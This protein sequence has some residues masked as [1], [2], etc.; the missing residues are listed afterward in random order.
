[1]MLLR[2]G[3]IR[4]SP[5]VLLEKSEIVVFGARDFSPENHGVFHRD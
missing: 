3:I 1:M 2:V 5:V 4:V